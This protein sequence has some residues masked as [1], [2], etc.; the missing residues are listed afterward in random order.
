M[1][2]MTLASLIQ[3]QRM[4]ALLI[5][6]ISTGTGFVFILSVGAQRYM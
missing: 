6:Q 2:V 1:E 5:P 4:A 3:A